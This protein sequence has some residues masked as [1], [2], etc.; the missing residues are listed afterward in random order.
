M[1]LILV[2]LI[3]VA[4]ARTLWFAYGP[5]SSAGKVLS[6]PE[7][8]VVLGLG[9]VHLG[10]GEDGRLM[11]GKGNQYL[12]DWL[13][14]NAASIR[15]VLAQKAISDGLHNPTQLPSGAPVLPMHGH[16]PRYP[17]R[18]LEALQL[19]LNRFRQRPIRLVLLCH[20]KHAARAKAN[21]QAL[22]PDADI[23]VADVGRVPYADAWWLAPLV[24]ACYELYL[25]RPA[26]WVRR[27]LPVRSPVEVELPPRDQ[28]S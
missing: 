18:T 28:G 17:V 5:S 23:L 13:E 7:D 10:E 16:D 4:L 19:A 1:V 14:R 21:L 22:A 20:D 26:D 2:G 12:A 11:V 25:A 6:I 8:S 3:L 24:W 27:W 9:F 15:L